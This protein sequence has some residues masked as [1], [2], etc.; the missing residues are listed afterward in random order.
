M[1]A[2]G[3]MVLAAMLATGQAAALPRVEADTLEHAYSACWHA[4]GAAG[5]TSVYVDC[6]NAAVAHFDGRG[7]HTKLWNA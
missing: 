6:V 1:R 5:E 2:L 4:Y 7:W 3:I